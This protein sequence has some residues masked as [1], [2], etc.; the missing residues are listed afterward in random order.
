MLCLDSALDS[1][2]GD[3]V[4]CVP[5]A[6]GLHGAVVTGAAWGGDCW[7]VFPVDPEPQ[8]PRQQ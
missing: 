4:V 1:W 8:P 3:A 5:G 2:P 6:M 7:A